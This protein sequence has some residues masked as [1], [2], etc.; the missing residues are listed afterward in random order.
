M[1]KSSPL[2]SGAPFSVAL[3]VPRTAPPGSSESS[4]LREAAAC[5]RLLVLL[6][7]MGKSSEL[8]GPPRSGVSSSTLPQRET[9]REGGVVLR[10]EV[11]L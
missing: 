4:V 10:K 5:L 11:V 8:T 1:G 2:V 7:I 3:R 9:G 6:G